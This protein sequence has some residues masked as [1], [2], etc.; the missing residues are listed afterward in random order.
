MTIKLPSFNDIV[1]SGLSL[2]LIAIF[3]MVLNMYVKSGI[4]YVPIVAWC[5]LVSTTKLLHSDARIR[6]ET[7]IYISI[8]LYALAVLVFSRGDQGMLS[9]T[10][11]L[12]ILMPLFSL[13]FSGHGK[14]INKKK[15]IT[16]I[17]LAFVIV[18]LVICIGQYSNYLF[19][20]GFP[21]VERY[22]FKLSISGT[23]TNPNDLSATLLVV[24]AVF[25]SVESEVTSTQRKLFWLASIAL[26]FICM[27][28]S[29]LIL[30]L[31]FFIST[32]KISLSYIIIMLIIMLILP[33]AST[34]LIE[35]K[36]IF[37][38]GI[39]INRFESILDLLSGLSSDDS[40]SQRVGSYIL[41]FSNLLS[42]GFG[43]MT[44]NDYSVYSNKAYL[45][46]NLMFNMP[47]S[48][49]IEMSY[50]LGYF[51]LL[52]VLSVIGYSFLRHRSKV[53]FVFLFIPSMFIP[54]SVLSNVI[55]IYFFVLFS[56]LVKE[57][58]F[59]LKK[60]ECK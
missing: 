8:S 42:L 12:F 14:D 31:I 43:S 51:G 18:Q 35:N 1:R 11:V 19:G 56:M 5:L 27:S 25:Y 57:S 49:I 54:S 4:I 13:S 55:Y 20:V 17:C 7:L 9:S 39:L 47:H 53:A 22:S 46:D 3:C 45:H 26:L 58:K 41:F 2:F 38:I 30:G 44:L 32:R 10:F 59:P 28:R 37:K 36:E 6:V 50:W 33:M 29:A 24:I 16:H 52:S 40:G 21:I 48:L 15:E 34:Y 23:F 60:M